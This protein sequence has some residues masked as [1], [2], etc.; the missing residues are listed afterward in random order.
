MKISRTGAIAGVVSVAA[1]MVLTA[2]GG[3]AEGGVDGDKVTLRFT[4]AYGPGSF[5]GDSQERWMKEVEELSDGTIEFK[6]F[7]QG[8][9]VGAAD[10]L[11]GISQGRADI[12]FIGQAYYPVELPLTN[13]SYL[14]QFDT[15][16][17]AI[18]NAYDETYKSSDL[19]QAEWEKQ[20]V[21]P[22]AWNPV[23]PMGLGSKEPI[24]SPNDFKGMTIRSSGLQT[25]G[26]E[27]FGA[28][29]AAIASQETYE[30]LQRGVVDAW[31]GLTI[32]GTAAMGYP[33]VASNLL[34]FPEFYTA[35]GSPIGINAD[36]WEQL[37]EA[38]KDAMTEA[39]ADYHEYSIEMAMDYEAKGCQKYL[40]SGGKVTQ[41]SDAE[42]AQLMSAVEG[43][44]E[45][46]WMISAEKAGLSKDG[47]DS[48]VSEFDAVYQEIKA[49]SPYT[50]GFVACL[51]T[52]EAGS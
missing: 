3:S 21:V 34:A 38:Q 12:G 7:W 28:G 24:E 27:K 20:N 13:V 52:Q 47:I 10:A 33:E 43:P 36:K 41:F 18:V 30:A 16:V 2:C 46:S 50:D 15:D 8:S 4:S 29:T 44:M 40:D 1:L 25:L 51:E 32:D 26:Y 14:P 9:L 37:S 39:S 11:P 6:R 35:T 5:F 48:F 49:D 45:D 23:V 17:A 22:L 19:F 42:R 31:G